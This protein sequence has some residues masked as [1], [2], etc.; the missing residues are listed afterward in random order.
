MR[1]SIAFA[2]G[3]GGLIETGRRIASYGGTKARAE[4]LYRPARVGARNEGPGWKPSG[5]GVIHDANSHFALLS[6][7]PQN[8]LTMFTNGP[9][10]RYDR[11][12]RSSEKS[13]KL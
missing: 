9:R 11:S 2:T 8:V 1:S 6:F 10:L 4:H 5:Q 7:S 12:V 3:A 13:V